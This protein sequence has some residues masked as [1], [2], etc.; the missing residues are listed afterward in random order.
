VPH[1]MH[2]KSFSSADA[3][4]ML[5]SVVEP[6]DRPAG[7]RLSTLDHDAFCLS[8][9]KRMNVIDFNKLS[10]VFLRKVVSTFRHHALGLGRGLRERERSETLRVTCRCRAVAGGGRSR[11]VDGIDSLCA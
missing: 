6:R 3:T 10:M 2:R 8:Q 5:Q 7:R 9:T 11:I 1:F 4:V